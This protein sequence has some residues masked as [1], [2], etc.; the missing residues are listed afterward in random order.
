MIQKRETY[1]YQGHTPEV[2]ALCARLVDL[3]AECEDPASCSGPGAGRDMQF[4]LNTAFLHP[5]L[6]ICKAP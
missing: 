4:N 1:N 6:I 2:D 5:R 3:C